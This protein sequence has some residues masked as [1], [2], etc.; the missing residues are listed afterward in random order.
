M[1]RG[2]RTE[3]RGRGAGAGLGAADAGRGAR[4]R[5]RNPGWRGAGSRWA[6]GAG[7]GALGGRE[8]GARG[9]VVGCGPRAEGAGP[10]GA[11]DAPRVAAGGRPHSGGFLPRARNA[12]DLVSA[13]GPLSRSSATAALSG[14][15][16]GACRS[17]N[18]VRWGL[19]LQSS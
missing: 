19:G 7:L 12:R 1:R 16:V 18:L 9:G 4:G 10:G 8:P 15:E 14:R 5:V 3:G 6:R 2:L 13:A 17:G 11:G